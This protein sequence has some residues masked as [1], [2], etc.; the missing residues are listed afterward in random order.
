MTFMPLFSTLQA[1][2]TY[3][4]SLG[5]LVLQRQG[6][7]G[8]PNQVSSKTKRIVAG[9]AAHAQHAYVLTCPFTWRKHAQHAYV[10][11]CPFTWRK[12]AQHAY[13]LTCPFTWRMHCYHPSWQEASWRVKTSQDHVCSVCSWAFVEGVCYGCLHRASVN[14][15]AIGAAAR[16]N[17]M[18]TFISQW[19][20]GP[21][22]LALQS[23][24]GHLMR[25]ICI[26]VILKFS[27]TALWLRFYLFVTLLLL[28]QWGLACLYHN[29][30]RL[31]L[32]V[33]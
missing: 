29:V 6:E 9:A 2:G 4:S 25:Y 28:Q 32:C 13:V 14:V 7:K 33:V 23:P 26:R 30:C 21:L 3:K 19:C 27:R 22:S 18:T 10:L 12:H 17:Y 20:N 5:R 15:G 24:N 31:T 11:T 16:K 1:W 8:G